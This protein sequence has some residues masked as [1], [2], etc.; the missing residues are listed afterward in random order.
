MSLSP[1]TLSAG[2]SNIPLYEFPVVGKTVNY[3]YNPDGVIINYGYDSQGRYR[4]AYGAL[5]SSSASSA[6]AFEG[7]EYSAGIHSIHLKRQL[8]AGEE[9]SLTWKDGHQLVIYEEDGV[10]KVKKRNGGSYSEIGKW[11][12]ENGNSEYTALYFNDDMNTKRFDKIET[13]SFE[14]F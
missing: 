14:E 13:K 1:I 9:V 7:K 11:K 5:S 6:F 10:T 3:L 2:K 4:V 8:T 12:D